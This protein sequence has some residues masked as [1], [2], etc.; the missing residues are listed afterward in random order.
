M[1]TLFSE[2]G[3]RFY[4]FTRDHEPIHVHVQNADGKAK[5]EIE[6]GIK[7]IF[8][9]GINTKD[10]K[11]AERLVE[12]HKDFFMAEWDKVFNNQHKTDEN[13]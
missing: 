11:I 1:P 13:K 8:N 2:N 5:F 3:L 4:F 10:L 12:K 7:L 9:T 6:N